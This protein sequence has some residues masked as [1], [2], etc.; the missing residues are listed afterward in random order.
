LDGRTQTLPA[1]YSLSSSDFH[2]VTSGNN[3]YAAGSGYDL[4]TGR[5]TPIVSKVAVDLAGGSSST[6]T[7]SIGSFAVNPTAVP[8]GGT[9][10]LTAS[11]G[12]GTGGTGSSGA[13]YRGSN[14]AAGLQTGSQPGGGG[15]AAA[16]AT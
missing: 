12:T 3:G 14:R 15:G 16:R 7:P 4:V 9:V 2:D 13:V 10:T 11:N 5:G 6:P 8:L 1:I